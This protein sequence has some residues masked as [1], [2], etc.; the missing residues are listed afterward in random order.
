MKKIIFSGLMVF[1]LT[2]FGQEVKLRKGIVNI[3]GKECFKYTSDLLANNT[4]FKSNDDQTL[5]FMDLLDGSGKGGSI[6]LYNKISVIGS[7][8][9]VT[10]S[11]GIDRKEVI[12]GMIL[13]GVIKDCAFDKD[14]FGDFAN[15]YDQHIESSIIRV[16]E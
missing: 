7:D 14:K 2:V 5:F 11:D 15:R 9:V 3:D 12:K 6:K 8:K 4:V 10:M 16:S 13:T 1:S